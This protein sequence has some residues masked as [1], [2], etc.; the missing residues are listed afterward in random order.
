MGPLRNGFD[1]EFDDIDDEDEDE[2]E[3]EEDDDVDICGPIVGKTNSF[4]GKRRLNKPTKDGGI[5]N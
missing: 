4:D 5:N 2:E 1:N 3:D